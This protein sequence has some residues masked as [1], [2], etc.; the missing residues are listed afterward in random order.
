MMTGMEEQTPPLTRESWFC[1]LPAHS[2][3]VLGGGIGGRELAPPHS[4]HCLASCAYAGGER[5]ILSCGT[6]H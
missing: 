1:P 2:T 5:F 6:G 4:G 3:V